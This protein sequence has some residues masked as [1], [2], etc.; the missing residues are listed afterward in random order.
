[1]ITSNSSGITFNATNKF[2]LQLGA[3]LIRERELAR[4]FGERKIEKIELKSESYQWEQTGNICIEYRQDG[5][6]S[7]ISVTEADMWVHELMRD[8]KTLVY[9]MFPIERLKELVK[10]AA[11]EGGKREHGGD[12]GRFSNVLIRLKDI[13][14]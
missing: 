11:Q 3:S 13:L 6:P 1:M 4:I 5:K 9:L 7:G 12:G 14:K 2:D 10:Q 8:G